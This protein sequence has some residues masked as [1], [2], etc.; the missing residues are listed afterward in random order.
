[1]HGIIEHVTTNLRK[2]D[3]KCYDTL[4]QRTHN[5]EIIMPE[6]ASW[7]FPSL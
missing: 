3:T 4:A 5:F 7:V 6:D 1:M 2:M